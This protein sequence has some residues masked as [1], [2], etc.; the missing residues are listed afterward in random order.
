MEANFCPGC[1]ALLQRVAELEAKVELLTRLLEEQRRAGKRQAAPFRK[2]PPK[3]DPK[4]PGRK[5]GSDHGSHGHRAPPPPEQ[6]DEIL[7]APLPEAC[8][9]C[10]GTVTET[11]IATQFQTEIPRQPLRRQFHIHVGCC[12]RCRRR[13][14]GRHPLQTSDAIGAAASQLGPDTQAAVVELNKTMGLPHGKIVQILAALF[15]IDLSRGA[16]AQIVLRAG[17]RLEPAYQEV[18][19]EIQDADQLWL[20]ETGWRLGGQPAWLHVWVSE[21]A[22][23][24]QVDRRR[25]ASVLEAV[26][27]RDWEGTLIHDGF[28]SYDRFTAAIHQQCL[29]HVLHRA[30]SLLETATRGAVHFPRQVIG[31]FTDAIHLRNEH[32][33][34]RGDPS[35]WEDA[36][37]SFEE[38]LSTLLDGRRMVPAYTRL[39]THLLNHFASWFSFLSDEA[40]PPT[41]AVGE[42]AVRPAV[43]NRKVWGGNRTPAGAQAQGVLTSVLRTC[44]QQALHTVDFISQTLRAFGNRLLPPPVLLPTR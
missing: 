27:G 40:V 37:D 15:G 41:N 13:L 4:R 7:E 42:Q 11:G 44:K 43:V 20:D 6:I 21:R 24:Y 35:V 16:S 38:R 5:A 34:G 29:F 12:D 14:Q 25:S 9:D 36:R 19:R 33:A 1:Q 8:P 26:I 32:L 17:Q 18:I 28:A 2:G 23:C 3:P 10:G 22:T 30:R 31:L 39:S